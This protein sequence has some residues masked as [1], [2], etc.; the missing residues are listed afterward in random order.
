[1]EREPGN[2]PLPP[3]HAF[4]SAGGLW[5]APFI[6][7]EDVWPQLSR[8]IDLSGLSLASCRR[9]PWGRCVAV[10][11]RAPGPWLSTAVSFPPVTL[12]GHRAPS[13]W[14][15]SPWLLPRGGVW[16][17]NCPHGIPPYCL[18]AQT[19]DGCDQGGAG[20]TPGSFVRCVGSAPCGL[21]FSPHPTPTLHAFWGQ[22]AAVQGTPS[23][24][25]GS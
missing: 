18:L 14:A 6:G 23:P 8:T 5:D 3:L 16:Y 19:I 13:L 11:A 10:W 25:S 9:D 2:G 12:C 4:L 24:L 22:K 20:G 1:M 17:A 21:Y 15:P 7:N